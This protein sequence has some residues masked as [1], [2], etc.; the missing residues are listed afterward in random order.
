MEA[1]ESSEEIKNLDI[2]EP[3]VIYWCVN[4]NSNSIPKCTI[5][6]GDKEYTY[7]IEFDEDKSV[8]IIKQE[9]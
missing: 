3:T 4:G 9:K 2:S 7:V 8:F 6:V 1:D 5:T